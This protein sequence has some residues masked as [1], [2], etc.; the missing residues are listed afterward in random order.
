MRTGIW[1]NTALLAFLLSGMLRAE[2]TISVVT[3]HSETHLLSLMHAAGLAVGSNLNAVFIDQETLKNELFVSADKNELPDILL[4][5]SD[6]AD[7]PQLRLGRLSDAWYDANLDPNVVKVLPT[8]AE[9]KAIP[10]VLGNHLLQFFNKSMV[11]SPLKR[12]EDLAMDYPQPQV[13]WSYNEMY[14]FAPFVMSLGVEFLSDGQSHLDSPQMVEALAYYEDLARRRVVDKYCQYQCSWEAFTSG[15]VPYHINGSWAIDGLK[16]AMGENLGIALL[17][18][19][20]GVPMRSYY[21]SFVM[22]FPEIESKSSEKRDI[23]LKFAL[24]MQSADVQ[25][26]LLEQGYQMPINLAARRTFLASESEFVSVFTRQLEQ[27]ISMP[28]SPNMLV[29]WDA[30]SRGFVRYSGGVLDAE[31]AARYMQKSFQKHVVT[32]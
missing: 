3:S 12:W 9:Q 4:I 31:G 16:D 13:S 20:K 32:K 27:S 7:L 14:W 24:K 8:V 1:I 18:S 23:L 22:V 11:S 2:S 29:L 21:S 5:P 10:L 19:I 30:M 25:I 17:P 26:A 15:S 28:D 6:I